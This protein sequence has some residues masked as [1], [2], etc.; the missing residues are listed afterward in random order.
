M[1]YLPRNL[2]STKEHERVFSEILCPDSYRDSVF[3]A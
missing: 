3:V 1:K 2:K